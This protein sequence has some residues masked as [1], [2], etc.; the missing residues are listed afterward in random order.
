MACLPD[1]CCAAVCSADVMPDPATGRRSARCSGPCTG[2]WRVLGGSL[3]KK[4]MRQHRAPLSWR[5]CRWWIVFQQMMSAPC[6]A[7]TAG[8]PPKRWM[9]RN[10]RWLL[11]LR[12]SRSIMMQ[13]RGLSG[14]NGPKN[15]WPMSMP[16]LGLTAMMSWQPCRVRQPPISE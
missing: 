8:T 11:P 6:S 3:N 2:M 4:A 15:C 12:V 10:A 16:P 7:V 14:W 1:R 9:T 5:P 13:C